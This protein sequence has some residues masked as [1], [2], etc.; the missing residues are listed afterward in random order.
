MDERLTG[1]F[2]L[3][4]LSCGWC[5]RRQKGLGRISAGMEKRLA[6]TSHMTAQ[7]GLGAGGPRQ[8]VESY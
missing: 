3:D 1:C 6:G 8:V 7:Q 5:E 4:W 2:A